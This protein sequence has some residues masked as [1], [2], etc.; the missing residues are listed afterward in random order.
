VSQHIKGCFEVDEYSKSRHIDLYS[1]YDCLYSSVILLFTSRRRE[2]FV[3]IVFGMTL[4]L[5]GCVNSKNNQEVQIYP[6]V[7]H[8]FARCCW[9]FFS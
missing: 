6:T 7:C 9:L 5:F 2:C 3:H 8:Q 1:G 4:L